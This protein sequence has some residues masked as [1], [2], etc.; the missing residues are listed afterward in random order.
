MERFKMCPHNGY[1]MRGYERLL[2][3]QVGSESC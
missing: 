3:C 2:T 1:P